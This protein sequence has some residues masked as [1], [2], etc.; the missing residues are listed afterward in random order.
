MSRENLKNLKA[1]NK[2]KKKPVKKNI[3]KKA[4]KNK[5]GAGDLTRKSKVK[6]M[7]YAWLAVLS[8]LIIVGLMLVTTFESDLP[9]IEALENPRSDESTNLYDANGKM[10]GTFFAMHT[11]RTKV[12]YQEL[13]EDLINALKSTED[14]RFL[15]HSG[16]D[17]RGLM[18]AIGGAMIGS[19]RGGASTISQQLAKM[20]FHE[21]A[22]S[23]YKRI[24]QKFAEWIIATRLEIVPNQD[25]YFRIRLNRR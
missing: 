22:K 21:P 6:I 25:L 16:V 1:K 12:T 18:R 15:D 3:S 19:N 7:L 5:S 13:P 23:S 4:S 2:P 8:P 11:N 20:M 9:S 10:I 14:K 24:R 17:G